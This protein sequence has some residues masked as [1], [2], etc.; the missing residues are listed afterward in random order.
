[1]LRGAFLASL[2]LGGCDV[3][4][5]PPIGGATEWSPPTTESPCVD[6]QTRE[7]HLDLGV[8]DGVRTCSSGKQD[9]HAGTW[10]ACLGDDVTLTSIKLH[11]SSTGLHTLSTSPTSCASPCDPSCVGFDDGSDGGLSA[12]AD[13][14]SSG[15]GGGWFGYM[16]GSP[17]GFFKKLVCA[18]PGY[19]CNDPGSYSCTGQTHCTKWSA[20]ED[21]FHCDPDGACKPSTAG[22]TWPTAI[23]PKGSGPD[24]TV[25]ASCKDASGKEGFTLCN[26]GNDTLPAQTVYFY[27]RFGNDFAWPCPDPPGTCVKNAESCGY[28]LAA[29]LAPGACVRIT[30]DT[31]CFDTKWTNGNMSAQ[32]DPQ[33]RVAECGTGPGTHVNPGCADNWADIKKGGAACSSLGAEVA[34]PVSYTFTY[35]AVC[36]SGKRVQWGK[37]AFE[38]STPCGAGGCATSGW[39]SVKFEAQTQPTL[40]GGGYGPATP[41]TPAVIAQAPKPPFGQDASCTMT[42]PL[43]ECPADLF[44]GLGGG[45]LET[46]NP[47]LNLKITL[48]PSAD[49]SAL[50]SVSSWKVT[51]SCKDSE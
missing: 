4:R 16:G 47:R 25:G 44:T 1:M 31:P 48:I 12:T 6:G 38:A 23:C 17:P 43:P 29:P 9:C 2:I 42:G 24:L 46:T 8:H 7:C 35:D 40:A 18:G 45:T 21:D 5:A 19:D 51:Y 20:C 32:V 11:A 50:P 10:S 41:A 27:L 37:L 26:R 36:P 28:P 15:G 22:W 33:Q 49:G 34:T 30:E 3:S 14:S 13:A 39:S